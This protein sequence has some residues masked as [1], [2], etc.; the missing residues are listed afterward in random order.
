MADHPS[1]LDHFID[2]YHEA[3]RI[4]REQRELHSVLMEREA[5]LISDCRRRIEESR[6][7]LA[8]LRFVEQSGT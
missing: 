2:G 7:L 6:K 4:L 1:L 3:E 5:R 8:A